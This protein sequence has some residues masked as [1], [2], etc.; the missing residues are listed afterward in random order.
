LIQDKSYKQKTIYKLNQTIQTQ[1]NAVLLQATVMVRCGSLK[2]NVIMK[3]KTLKGWEKS[4]VDLDKYIDEPCEI[5]EELYCYILEIVPT[6]YS[7]KYAQQ[8][9]DACD[10]FEN[11][12]GKKVFT[13]MTVKS[14]N[15]KYF[16]LGILPEFKG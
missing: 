10:S 4:K 9:G 3:K 6:H 15:S 2:T 16:Y 8:G 14:V 7:S 1:D 11:H 12:K 5:D 13:Y